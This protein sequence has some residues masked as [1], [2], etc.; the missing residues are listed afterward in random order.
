MSALPKQT[1]GQE[2]QAMRLLRLFYVRLTREFALTAPPCEELDSPTDSPSKED[3]SAARQW[4]HQM[5]GLIQV[6]QLRQFLQ[7]TT[8][9]NEETLVAMA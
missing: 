5:D 3:M 4:F 6:H 2:W 1:P 8:G 9:V 7:T